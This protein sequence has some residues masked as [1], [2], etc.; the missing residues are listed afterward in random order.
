MTLISKKNFSLLPLLVFFTTIILM[1]LGRVNSSDS[2]SFSYDGFDLNQ[3]RNLVFQGDAHL[4]S[5]PKQFTEF[6]TKAL[7]L[8]K[9]NTTD[10]DG[11]PQQ[12]TVGRVLYSAP[13]RL[14]VKG[15]GRVSNFESNINAQLIS[16]SSSS[17][18]ADGLAFFISPIH[19][20]IPKHS[21]GGYLGLFNESTAFNSSTS[22]IVAIEFDTYSNTWDPNYPHIGINVNSINSS[23]HVR[24]DME[25][26]GDFNVHITY[27]A[28][29]RNLSVASFYYGGNDYAVSYVADLPSVLPEWV[30]VGLT[31]SSGK[32]G[33][34]VHTIESW[35]FKSSLV[36]I[37]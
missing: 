37:K 24:W 27:D 17:K 5:W 6:E 32:D 2:T 16:K 31:A 12:N 28:L 34:Q 30:R 22:Q 19:S 14:Y 13:I 8:T 9:L 18:P 23:A 7:Q 33:V 36:S 29:S 21:K 26:V 10:S 11:Y 1:Q 20:N 3:E 15:E 4:A 35:D 25:V